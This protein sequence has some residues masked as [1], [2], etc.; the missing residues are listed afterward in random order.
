MNSIR[1]DLQRFFSESSWSDRSLQSYGDLSREYLT[2]LIL[3]FFHQ[4]RAAMENFILLF[5]MLINMR[6]KVQDALFRALYRSQAW[7]KQHIDMM[8]VSSIQ[9][10]NFIVFSFVQLVDDF[11]SALSQAP[12]MSRSSTTARLTIVESIPQ[13]QTNSLRELHFRH[14]FDLYVKARTTNTLFQDNFFQDDQPVAITTPATVTPTIKPRKPKPTGT[15][16]DNPVNPPTPPIPPASIGNS[17]IVTPS[18]TVQPSPVQYCFFFASTKGCKSR[19]GRRK[20][21]QC[22]L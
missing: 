13:T 7:V 19:S 11:H 1:M 8:G 15:R 17:N 12:A 22:R 4:G 2:P 9:A 14:A 6:F 3:D 21:Q 5:A 18:P 10:R 16:K 20:F